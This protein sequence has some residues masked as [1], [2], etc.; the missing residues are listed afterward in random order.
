MKS[1]AGLNKKEKDKLKR[2]QHKLE[3]SLKVLDIPEKE[4]YLLFRDDKMKVRMKLMLWVSTE[5]KNCTFNCASLR[6]L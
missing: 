6:I 5:R 4:F 1:T 2:K 3:R